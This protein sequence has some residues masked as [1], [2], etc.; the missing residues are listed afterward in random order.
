MGRI[1]LFLT[2]R[3]STVIPLAFAYG[4]RVGDRRSFSLKEL[5]IEL[6]FVS[7]R[8]GSLKQSREFYGRLD[9]DF[10][11]IPTAEGREKK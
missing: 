3:K 8:S 6:I 2:S 5:V 10:Y 1:G 9:A 7:G 4:S 11:G